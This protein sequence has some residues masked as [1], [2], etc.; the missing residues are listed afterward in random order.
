M[1]WESKMETEDLYNRVLDYL[2]YRPRSEEELRDYLRE[3]IENFEISGDPNA[4]IS[5]ILARLVRLK[6]LN[7]EEFVRW[8][9]GQR[10]ASS[11][12]RGLYYIRSELHQK[13]IDGKLV[14]KV[15]NELEID[16]YVLCKKAATN[17]A[18]RYDLEDLKERKKLF[19]YL[20]RRGFSYETAR[21]VIKGL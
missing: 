4:V 13:G 2:S 12:P 19:D 3:K 9:I 5:S 21:D 6:L 7:D 8:W 10:T 14:E 11:K 15:W 18:R 20:L 1:L 16:A 17:R